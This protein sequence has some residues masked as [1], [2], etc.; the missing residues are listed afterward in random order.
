MSSLFQFSSLIQAGIEAGKLV[1]VISNTGIPLSM[2]RDKATGQ[3]VAHAVGL[4]SNSI[5]LNPIMTP[6]QLLFSGIG[7]YQTHKGFQSV[8]KG[9]HSLQSSVGVL[10]SSVQVLQTTTSV[11]GVLGATT[12]VLGAVN[13]YQ[14]LKLKKAVE[15]LDLKVENGFINLEQAILLQGKELASIIHSATQ[16]IKFET[17]RVILVRAYGLFATA[18]DRLRVAIRFENIDRRNSEID[19]IRG[20]LYQALADYN[21]PQL[22]E[23]M[24]A[25][26]QLRRQECVWSIEQAIINTYQMQGELS[27]VTEHLLKLQTNIRTDSVRTISACANQDELNFL[28]P[29]ISRIHECDLFLLESWQHQTDW[30]RSLPSA[31]LK[32]FTNP[33]S[34]IDNYSE[35]LD[36]ISEV[37]LPEQNLQEDVHDRAVLDRLLFMMDVDRRRKAELYIAQKSISSG[38]KTLSCQNLHLASDT[39]VANLYS[40]FQSKDN[41]QYVLSPY[42]DQSRK[43]V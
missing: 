8:E 18:L 24:S 34:S 37:E 21:N 36:N 10:Q 31:E 12:S 42:P 40:Y 22:L 13:L 26:A 25:P 14:T 23:N 3:F 9:L 27:A 20:M 38:H 11:I 1:Q 7:I 15:N 35:Q 28:A 5:S 17:Q 16:D 19:A 43:V 30:M 33:D 39:A 29:E 4:V 41:L 6:F 2:V 32:S